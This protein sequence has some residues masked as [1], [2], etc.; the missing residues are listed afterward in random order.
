MVAAS[1]ETFEKTNNLSLEE[2]QRTNPLGGSQ[3][4]QRSTEKH[5]LLN[6][7]EMPS[8]FDL[9]VTSTWR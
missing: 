3:L 8:G 4:L 2:S 5:H 1:S 6:A 7:T 9:D